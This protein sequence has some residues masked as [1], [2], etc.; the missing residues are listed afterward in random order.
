MLN[1]LTFDCSKGELGN[2]VVDH[3]HYKR[4]DI[5]RGDEAII[6]LYDGGPTIRCTMRSGRGAN[7]PRSCQS[8]QTSVTMVDASCISFSKSQRGQCFVSS[9]VEGDTGH[10]FYINSAGGVYER[11]SAN[12]PNEEEPSGSG[13]RTYVS[14]SLRGTSPG[15]N[16]GR[17]LNSH[18]IIDVLVVYTDGARADAVANGYGSMI[19]L[20]NLA[21]AE[22]NVAYANSGINAELRL[23]H[24]HQDASGYTAD[25]GAT[26]LLPVV[27]HLWLTADGQLDYVH[28]MR[29]DYCA[30]MVHLVSTG[31]GAGIAMNNGNW[32]TTSRQFS[33]SNYEYTTGEFMIV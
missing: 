4:F 22:T 25:V 27:N 31:V 12:F 32:P 1:G 21:I 3:G 26:S 10:I 23:A 11:D 13:N 9:I 8:G 29:T 5:V 33:V 19:N 18:P 24:A 17:N 20:I 28:K 30:D 7:N 15:V 6:E 14:R 16:L 2:D